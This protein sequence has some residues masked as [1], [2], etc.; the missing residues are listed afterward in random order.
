[1][2]NVYKE[3]ANPSFTAVL[4]NHMK[5]SVTVVIT[6]ELSSRVKGYDGLLASLVLAVSR[7]VFFDQNM[8]VSR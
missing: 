5:S 8:C 3:L 4:R 6:S 2:G 1:M 7:N